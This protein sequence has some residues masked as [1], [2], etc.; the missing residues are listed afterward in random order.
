MLDNKLPVSYGLT[1]RAGGL[2]GG[3]GK[4]DESKRKHYSVSLAGPPTKPLTPAVG[5]TLAQQGKKTSH[6]IE[7]E[8]S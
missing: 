8:K 7:R 5:T 6:H 2:G 3:P 1:M 4:M